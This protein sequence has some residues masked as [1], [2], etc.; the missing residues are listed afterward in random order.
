MRT[1]ASAAAVTLLALAMAGAQTPRADPPAGLIVGQVVDAGTSRPIAGAVVGISG[2]IS[3]P[4]GRP[5]S[6]SRVL[7]TSDGRFVFRGLR[8]GHFSLIATKPGYVEGA[9][10][11]RRPGGPAQQVSLGEGERTGDV[12]IRMWRHGAISGTVVDEAGEPVIG[13]AVIAFT[14]SVTMSTRD[15]AS[16]GAALTDDRGI[17]RFGSLQPAEYIVAVIAVHISIP[18]SLGQ[19][20]PSGFERSMVVPE[21]GIAVMQMS[22]AS[23]ALMQVGDVLYAVG[24]GMAVPPP[25][26]GDRMFVYPTTYYPSATAAAQAAVLSVASGEERSG[27][28]FQLRP[29]TAARVAGSISGPEGPVTTALRLLPAD[30]GEAGFE[31]DGPFTVSDALGNFTFPAVPAGQ[32][33]LQARLGPPGSRGDV[34]ATALWAD[35]PLT[36]GDRDVTGV[37]VLLQP[38][39]RISG[40]FEFEGSRERPTPQRLQQV[41]IAI[42]LAGRAMLASGPPSAVRVEGDGRFTSSGLPPG[43]YFVRISGSPTGWRFKAATHDGR[44]IADLPLDLRGDAQVVITFSDRWNNLRGNVASAR[45]APDPEAIVLLFPTD[46]QQWTYAGTNTRRF[47]TARVTKSGEYAIGSIPEGD[48]YVVAVAD[49]E[50]GGW[51]DPK[52]LDGLARV[53]SRVTI[54]EGETRTQPL[55]TQ[56]VR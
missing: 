4:G 8:A 14:R 47:K 49:Q 50:A 10:G 34:G 26:S 56:E 30:A 18:A 40:R 45:G 21:L 42:Q 48:Y 22:G 5:L 28:D 7:T 33:S 23:P 11:R 15:L 9:Y 13:A 55:R 53:A 2:N 12:V 25:P 37:G 17:Y 35:V 54:I 38:G 6:S 31:A 3:T 52:V 19:K 41:P 43:R 24:G 1:L 16:R 32:Y 27:L 36:V 39:F 20:A 51:L 29:V 46:V 44:D